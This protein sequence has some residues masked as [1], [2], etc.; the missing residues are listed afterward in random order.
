MTDYVVVPH[1]FDELHITSGT[2]VGDITTHFGS[3]YDANKFSLGFVGQG[4]PGA[5]VLVMG[6]GTNVFTDLD[7]YLR[8]ERNGDGNTVGYTYNATALASDP[9]FQAA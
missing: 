3:S 9:G 7:G 2:T 8:A 5:F 1:T 6:D 4:G